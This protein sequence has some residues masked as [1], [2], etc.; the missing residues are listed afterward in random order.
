MGKNPGTTIYGT[1]PIMTKDIQRADVPDELL[2]DYSLLF[3]YQNDEQYAANIKSLERKIEHYRLQLDLHL[4]RTHLKGPKVLDFPIG[5]GRLYPH[6]IDEYELYGFD[7]CANYV[8][9]AGERYPSRR[10]RFHVQAFETLDTG[11]KFDSAYTLRTLHGLKNITAAFK[12][13]SSIIKPKGRWLFNFPVAHELT[14]QMPELLDTHGFSV[15]KR[16]AYDAYVSYGEMPPLINR[17]YGSLWMRAIDRRLVPTS[18]FNLVDRALAGSAM[19]F[20]VCERR[21]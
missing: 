6:L 3:K 5:T 17:L 21:P 1:V 7:I 12:G 8:T 20:Y 10:D 14:D 15:I 2:S 4:L 18:L 9:V 13:V 16:K 11:L 19:H